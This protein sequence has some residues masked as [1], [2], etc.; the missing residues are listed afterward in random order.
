MQSRTQPKASP[1]EAFTELD[2]YLLDDLLPNK[3]AHHPA[4]SLGHYIMKLARLGGYLARAHDLPP[5]NTVIW[6][7]LWRLT[8]IKLR[9]YLY[10]APASYFYSALDTTA[11]RLVEGHHQAE[12]RYRKFGQ[13]V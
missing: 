1:N 9:A 8:D 6:R 12:S 7:G 4:A 11:A 13:G 10:S 2:Q 3:P 5:G